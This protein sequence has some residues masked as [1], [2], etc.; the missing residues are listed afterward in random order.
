MLSLALE[1]SAAAKRALEIAELNYQEG[2]MTDIDL[3]E[4]R[5][6]LTEAQNQLFG[7]RIGKELAVVEY[8]HAIGK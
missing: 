2:A 7:A 6:N 3:L 5:K 4:K 1:G 8:E